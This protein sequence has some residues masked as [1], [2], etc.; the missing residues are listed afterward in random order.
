ME[1]FWTGT[2]LLIGTIIVA[3]STVN[4]DQTK[5]YV[6]FS[7]L[8]LIPKPSKLLKSSTYN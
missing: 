3:K 8:Y 6:L 1:I 5:S 2:V 4:F 7:S